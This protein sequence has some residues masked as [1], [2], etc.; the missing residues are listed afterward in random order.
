[1]NHDLRS[2][3]QHPAALLLAGA[4]LVIQGCA[5]TSPPTD[6]MERAD[7]AIRQ[8]DQSGAGEHAPLELKFARQKY[9]E[10]QAAVS[11]EDHGDA[12]LLAEQAL[13]NA[14]LA[15]AKTSAARARA[16]ASQVRNAV[17]S[18]RDELL[19]EEEGNAAGS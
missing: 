9:A 4:L 11:R 2:G 10:A 15:D 8:A 16:A 7:S 14:E 13:A 1:M 12:R 18:L 17:E 3:L 5:T 19:R 6:L